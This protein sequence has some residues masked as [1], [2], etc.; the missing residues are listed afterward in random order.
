MKRWMFTFGLALSLLVLIMQASLAQGQ[1]TELSGSW[2]GS[3][4]P[5]VIDLGIDVVF[6]G[7]PDGLSATLDIP[8]QGLFGFP[9]SEVAWDGGSLRFIMAGVPGDPVFEGEGDGDRIDG[10]F[11]QGGSSLPFF[12]ERVTEEGLGSADRRP[13]EPRP[14]FPYREQ[15]VSYTGSGGTIAGTLTLPEGPGPFA[16]ALLITGSGPQDRDEEIFGHKPFLV[17]ADDLTRA[18]MAVLRVDDRGVGGSGGL[19]HEASFDDLVDDAMAG[20][21]FLAAHPE[22]DAGRMGLI[23]HSQGGYVAPGVA[24][25]GAPVAFVVTIAGPAVHGYEVLVLQNELFITEAMRRDPSVDQAMIDEAVATQV[26]FLA[27][28]RDLLGSGDYDGAAEAV[29]RQVEQAYEALPEDQRPAPDLIE[30]IVALQVEGSVTPS[31]ASF[32]NFDPQP[33]LRELRVPTLAIYGGLDLQVDAA[34]SEG[35]MRALL[36]EAGNRD[37]SVVTFAGLNHLMQPAVTGSVDEYPLIET[38]IDPIVLQ[39][40]RD[41]LVARFVR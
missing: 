40:M 19:D 35:P 2:R 39:T 16:A 41:W 29:R 22:I 10:T 28:L 8:A 38:T 18:G 13:Q 5:G 26:A 7:G 36:T 9:L 4:G 17:I 12:I 14:P 24:A 27:E 30:Q 1:E 34:Q 31:L 23:G 3:I 6:A 32:M 15:E 25:R 37:F 11:T 33:Y 20:L 21:A